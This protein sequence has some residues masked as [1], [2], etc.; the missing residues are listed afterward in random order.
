MDLRSCNHDQRL[1]ALRCDRCTGADRG[2][3]KLRR[4]G[5]A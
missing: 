3:K 2:L 1:Q 5:K 4:D